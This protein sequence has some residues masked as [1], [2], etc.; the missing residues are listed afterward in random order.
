MYVEVIVQVSSLEIEAGERLVAISNRELLR[1]SSH[2]VYQSLCNNIMYRW[3]FLPRPFLAVDMALL[4]KGDV[5]FSSL[6]PNP[7]SSSKQC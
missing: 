7:F 6:Y 1:Q 5:D 3:D 2:N 4:D